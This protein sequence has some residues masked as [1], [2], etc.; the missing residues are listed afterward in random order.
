[1]AIGDWRLAFDT[2]S[3]EE[4]PAHQYV[5]REG[6]LATGVNAQPS[7]GIPLYYSIV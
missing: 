7:Q 6:R 5:I 3:R 1:M 2:M 4:A